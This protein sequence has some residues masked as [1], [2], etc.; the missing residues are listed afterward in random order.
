[1]P[2]SCSALEVPDTSYHIQIVDRNLGQLII[3]VPFNY[4]KYISFDG[5]TFINQYSSTITLPAQTVSAGSTTEYSIRCRSFYKPD[6]RLSNYN[7]Y[8]E[9]DII[10]V[11][12]NNLPNINDSDFTIFS[13]DTLVNMIVCMLAGSVVVLLLKKR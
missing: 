11:L 5:N 6:Y 1:M 9:L 13:Q 12:Y 8:R 2:L 3:A 4:A 10:E 7:D